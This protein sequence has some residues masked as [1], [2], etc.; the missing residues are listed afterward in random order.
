[1]LA[2]LACSAARVVSVDRLLDDL[3]G[4]DLPANPANGLQVRVSKLRR[5]VGEVIRRMPGGC[6]LDVDPDDVHRFAPLVSGRRFED[7]IAL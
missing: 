7:A 5:Q 2:L 4:E 1:M 3:W 6:L